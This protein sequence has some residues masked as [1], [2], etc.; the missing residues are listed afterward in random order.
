MDVGGI[1]EIVLFA[2]FGLAIVI[3]VVGAL[4]NIP[5]HKKGIYR[6]SKSGE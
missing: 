3:I 4:K 6:T 2:A 5:K 1:I